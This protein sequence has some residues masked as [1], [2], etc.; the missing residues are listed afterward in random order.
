MKKFYSLLFIMLLAFVGAESAWGQLSLEDGARYY[1]KYGTQYVFK[2][3]GYGGIAALTADKDEAS[4]FDIETSWMGTTFTANEGALSVDVFNCLFDTEPEGFIVE[5]NN[6]SFS[7]QY[8]SNNLYITIEMDMLSV[9]GDSPD[10]NWRIEKVSNSSDLDP[11]TTTPTSYQVNI[12]G[13]GEDGY[14]GTFYADK[15]CEIPEGYT[16]YVVSSVSNGAVELNHIVSGNDVK[17]NVLAAN[18]PVIIKGNQGTI[19]LPVSKSNGSSASTNLLAGSLENGSDNEAGFYYYKL[20]Y[21]SEGTKLGFY[22]EAGT[23]GTSI[24]THPNKAYLKVP[25]SQAGSNALSFRFVD[26]PTGIKPVCA[27]QNETIYNLQGQIVKGNVS[28]V[29]VKS[30][31]K[32]IVK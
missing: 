26:E 31:K 20:A 15:A 21:N 17:G 6:D 7:I 3:V 10:S 19:E 22:W 16:A 12:L 30:G 23:G 27:N 2:D 29:Y 4:K 24:S 9:S 14:Y 25:I 11:G 5:G 1:L 32:Y 8:F 18:T 28:G 13:Q